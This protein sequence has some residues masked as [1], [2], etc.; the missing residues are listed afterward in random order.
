MMNTNSKRFSLL[1]LVLTFVASVWMPANQIAFAKTDNANSSAAVAQQT[2][3]WQI[4][5]PPGGDVRTIDID[6][7]DAQHLLIGTLDGQIYRSQDG[8]ASWSQLKNFSR[9]GLY[10]DHIIIDPRNSGTI[11]VAAHRHKESGGFF[12]STDGG[13]TWRESAQLRA[14]ALHSMTQDS[15]NQDTLLVGT[16]N[17]VYRSADAGETWTKLSVVGLTNTNVESLAIDP[18]NSNTIYAGTWYRLY[19][20]TNGGESWMLKR[21][22][23]IDDSD[24]FAI[25]IDER[26][27]DHIIASA[28]SGIYETY[29]AAESW[30]KVQGIPSTSRRTRAILLHPTQAGVTFAGTTEG[31][32]RSMK[33]SWMVTTSKQ[34]EI[35]SIAVHPKNPQTVFIGTNNYGVMISR[36][37]GKTFAPSNAGFSG[38]LAYAVVPDRERKGR[39]YAAT[40]NTTTGGGFF[41]VSND[42][43]QTWQAS[44]RNMPN[45]LSTY[46]ILQDQNDPNVIYLGTNL[47]VYRSM[48]RG[49]SWSA[50]GAPKTTPAR[51]RGARGR[52]G[53]TAAARGRTGASQTTAPPNSTLVEQVKRAQQALAIAGYNVGTP[54]GVMGT[55][56]TT[57]LRKFQSDK[58]IPQTGKLDEATLVALGLAGGSLNA[59]PSTVVSI[60]QSTPV[61]L[62]DTVNALA[63]T[64]DE[65]DGRKGILAATNAG[66]FRTY[67]PTVGW[68]RISYGANFDSRTLCVS[69]NSQNPPTLYVGTAKSGALVSRDNGKTWQQVA[70]VPVTVPVNAIEQD[71][72]RSAYVYIGT[73]QTLWVSHDGGEK[74]MRRG[75][76]LPIGT[77]TSILINPA[78]GD[79]IFVGNAWDKGEGGGVYRSSDA[80]VSWQRVDPNLPSRRVWSLAFDPNDKEKIFVGSHSAGVYTMQRNSSSD[81]ATTAGN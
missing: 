9:P 49:A 39:I 58:N 62:T 48:D 80:G 59:A 19:K 57:A 40:I 30:R 56:T 8:G 21:N 46:A 3:N 72:Q 13:E 66:L 43:G 2:G 24:V 32:W 31:F 65:R 81:A 79:E 7:Q 41:F 45:R 6:P 35:N 71:P 73:T 14:E 63:Y 67:D 77:Y 55:R 26:N 10:I 11:Y 54:D 17:G 23:M 42:A 38:R 53:A 52:R 29:D 22:G 16:N 68:E 50:I 27:P 74:W 25:D 78:N 1:I 60:Q 28:C 75:G 15:Q 5:G 33:N 70:G 37:G 69:V 51:S 4:T 44:M 18:R 47:G 36:D 76:G 61:V 64:F 34:L 20:T 12:K